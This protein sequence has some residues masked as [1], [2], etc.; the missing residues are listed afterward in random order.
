VAGPVHF[1]G[2]PTCHDRKWF[3]RAVPESWREGF[4]ADLP[5]YESGLVGALREHVRPGDR[6]VVVGGGA[7]VTAAVAALQAGDAGRVICFEGA[8]EEVEQVRRT[9]ERNRLDGR[10]TVHHAVVARSI[11]VYGTEPDRPA[12][13]PTDLPDCDLL[14]LDCEGAEIDILQELII[15]PHTILVETH[16]DYGAPTSLVSSLLESRGYR[17]SERGVAESRFREYC[18]RHDIRVLV[19]T[20]EESPSR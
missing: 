7:G 3:D 10:L 18:E 5:E 8:R 17:V 11:A 13:P 2:I 19:G 6:V 1:A 4:I 14:E 12:L 20:R 9:A 16:G 15:T